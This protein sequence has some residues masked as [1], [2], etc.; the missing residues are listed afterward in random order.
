MNMSSVKCLF[1]THKCSFCAF[2]SRIAL[3]NRTNR[4]SLSE[5]FIRSVLHSF[6]SHCF[7]S[8]FVFRFNLASTTERCVPAL[9]MNFIGRGS[10]RSQDSGKRPGNQ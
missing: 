1:L 7:Q 5:S 10:C 2:P 8:T 6:L 4:S 9:K 3:K